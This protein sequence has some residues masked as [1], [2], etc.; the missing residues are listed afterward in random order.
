FLK[1]PKFKVRPLIDAIETVILPWQEKIDWGYY[2]PYMVSGV[3]NQHPRAAMAHMESDKKNKVTQFFD[4]MTS[5]AD[6]E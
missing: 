5:A 3:L 4:Q 6:L 2:I 1:N